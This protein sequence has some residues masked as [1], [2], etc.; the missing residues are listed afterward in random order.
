MSTQVEIPGGTAMI[1]DLSDMSV[2]QRRM[3]QASFMTTGHIYTRIPQEALEAA[4]KPGQKSVDAQ[5]KISWMLASL[6]LTQSEA[7]SLL[8]LQDASIVAF[9]ESWTLEQKLPTLDNVQDLKPELYD[10]L[11]VATAGGAAALSLGTVNMEPTPPGVDSPFDESATSNK[12]SGSR[13]K[14]NLKLTKTQQNGGE[15]T[16]TEHSTQD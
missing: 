5:K 7:E 10:A 11:A 12:D 4:S 6:P 16:V 13:T 3:V 2:R 9:L 14:K 15:N 1:R 8:S